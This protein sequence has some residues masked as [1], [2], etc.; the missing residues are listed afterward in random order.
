MRNSIL[1]ICLI[2][3]GMVLDGFAFYSILH[4]LVNL[5][6]NLDLNSFFRIINFRI[7]SMMFAAVDHAR[8]LRAAAV[9]VVDRFNLDKVQV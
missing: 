6:P 5:I 1:Q 2:L 4:S 7:F 8:V 3:L 9:G